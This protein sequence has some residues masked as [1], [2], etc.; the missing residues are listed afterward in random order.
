VKREN[1]KEKKEKTFWFAGRRWPFRVS[2]T[3]DFYTTKPPVIYFRCV[4]KRLVIFVL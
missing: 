1:G 3:G 4:I 2:W